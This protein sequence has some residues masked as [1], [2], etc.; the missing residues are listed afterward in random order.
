MPWAK[1]KP[2]SFHNKID[3]QPHKQQL[4]AWSRHSALHCNTINFTALPHRTVASTTISC[5]WGQCGGVDA[6]EIIFLN[7]SNTFYPW[8]FL[9][10]HGLM[11][12]QIYNYYWYNCLLSRIIPSYVCITVWNWLLYCIDQVINY[13]VINYCHRKIYLGLL[14]QHL[15][16]YSQDNFWWLKI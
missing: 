11:F 15:H 4:T 1:M 3:L 7:S 8:M 10:Y 5:Y 6:S 12:S 14:D 2:S 9:K 16:P 13:L